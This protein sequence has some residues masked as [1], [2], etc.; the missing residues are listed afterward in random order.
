M[1]DM[2]ESQDYN[3]AGAT[4]FMQHENAD[5]LAEFNAQE[6]ARLVEAHDRFL[7]GE[8]NDWTSEYKR[9]CFV[10]WLYEHGQLEA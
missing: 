1:F 3:T 10:R 9:L 7:R 4:A 8:L 5:I 2:Y 6:A